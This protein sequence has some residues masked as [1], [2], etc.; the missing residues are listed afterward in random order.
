[1]AKKLNLAGV[2]EIA[3]DQRRQIEDGATALDTP[4][5]FP[6][7]WKSSKLERVEEGI[8]TAVGAVVK[9]LQ[10]VCKGLYQ[11]QRRELY[12]DAGFQ[13]FK[14][15]IEAGRLT[16]SISTLYEY[17]RI[18]RVLTEYAP[19]LEDIAFTEADGLK[20]VLFLEK[21]IETTGRKADV[22]KHLKADSYRDFVNYAKGTPPAIMHVHNDSPPAAIAEGKRLLED[23]QTYLENSP[24]KRRADFIRL[25]EII[26][27]D[28]RGRG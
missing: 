11:I 8:K 14:A 16:P 6:D 23:V 9:N 12:R 22:F 27:D 18:G 10:D 26:L 13:D 3:A 1:M 21:A 2:Q 19:Q 20:K 25:L 5:A 17:S 24:K 15:Y 7:F 28:Y 4:Q